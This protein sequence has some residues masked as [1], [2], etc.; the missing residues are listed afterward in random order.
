MGDD[1]WMSVFPTLLAPNMTH[2]YDSFN[3]EDLHTVDN[4]VIQHLFPL[5]HDKSHPADVIIGHG[6]GVDHVGH[7]VGPD[8][9][10]MKEKLEQMDRLLRDVTDL[11]DDRTL[12]VVLG[13]HGMDSKGDHGGDGAL[14]TSAAT[15]IY[16]KRI[17]LQIPAYAASLDSRGKE[18]MITPNATFPGASHSFRHIQQIDLLPTL[19][20]LLGLPVPFNSLGTVIPELFARPIGGSNPETASKCALDDALRINAEQIRN[21]LGAYRA[22]GSG[23]ELDAMW[24]TL[25]TTWAELTTP[26][27]EPGQNNSAGGGGKCG[28]I[29][30]DAYYAY[31][32]FALEACRAMWAQFNVGL[33][34]VGLV[35][36]LLGVVSGTLIYVKLGA[37]SDWERWAGKRANKAIRHTL[38]G[39]AASIVFYFPFKLADPRLGFLE[40]L[41]IATSIASCTGL[42][43]DTIPTTKLPP[44]K[45]TPI[46]LVFHAFTF[47]SNSFTFWED[48]SLTYFLLS[49]LVPSLRYG[50]TA[51]DRR[52]KRRIWFFGGIFALCVRLMAISTVC[53]EEQQPY[54]RVTFYASSTLPSPPLLVR[55]LS[56]PAALALPSVLRRTLAISQSDKGIVSRFLNTL[57]RPA[58]FGASICWV[59]EW[60]ESSGIMIST[61]EQA[62]YVRLARTVLAWGVLALLGL[63]YLVWWTRPICFEFRRLE[64]PTKSALSSGASTVSTS[65]ASSTT[66][67]LNSRFKTTVVLN[68]NAYGS[69][70]LL[71]WTIFLVLAFLTSQLSAQIVLFLGTVALL[72]HLELADSV[73][74]AQ[75]LE[76]S[77]SLEKLTAALELQRSGLQ[78]APFEFTR[79]VAPIAMLA[80]HTF[81][82]TGHQATF[83]SLQWKSAFVLT[84]TLTYPLA[85]I[86]VMLNTFGPHFI[87][88]LAVPLLACWQVAPSSS[89]GPR[90]SRVLGE[91][92]RASVGLSLYHAVLLLFSAASSAWLRRHLMVWKVFAP[93]YIYAAVGLLVVDVAVLIANGWAVARA[94]DEVGK[95]VDG[96]G[97]GMEAK[98]S[99]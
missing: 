16:S 10:M 42:L 48:R 91:S 19:S 66:A 69:P 99:R 32:R 89:S 87:F 71:F 27:R 63:A 75:A 95:V 98:K 56:I 76:A 80:L 9:P 13:D 24:G 51:P 82:A 1:T 96:V 22:S 29:D 40:V 41:L 45:S 50:F 12:L 21:Y 93:R 61:S 94:T 57:I 88:S 83:P 59:L 6:L 65:A 8:H 97:A 20:L 85:P 30:L 7:R 34:S 86:L 36:I 4:G 2:P 68:S 38:I 18:S 74:D 73:R 43:I 25:E 77:F 90:K 52:L 60:V 53:R 33:I 23:S 14:E 37:V 49:S 62:A 17:P 47:L 92:L 64:T 81:Y 58:L 28:E 39:A 11:I 54:C 78:N 5:L 44:L 72:A 84:P 26:K 79:H 70:V 3:V 15:W 67:S 55:I 35:V 31:T 46:L